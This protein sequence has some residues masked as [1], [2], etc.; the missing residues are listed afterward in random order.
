MTWYGNLFRL[1]KKK[2]IE[3]IIRKYHTNKSVGILN[4]GMA[5]IRC[6][7]TLDTIKP[8]ALFNV[9]LLAKLDPE[10]ATPTL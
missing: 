6:K 8:N 5:V 2:W 1:T 9:G 4:I 3:N 10:K 7:H